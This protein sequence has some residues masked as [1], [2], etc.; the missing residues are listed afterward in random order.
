MTPLW[1]QGCVHSVLPAFAYIQSTVVAC[2]TKWPGICIVVH[3]CCPSPD[4]CHLSHTFQPLSTWITWSRIHN[5]NWF[6]ICHW[7]GVGTWCPFC[8]DKWRNEEASSSVRLMLCINLNSATAWSCPLLIPK[9]FV[10]LIKNQKST[11]LWMLKRNV[12]TWWQTVLPA[13]QWGNRVYRALQHTPGSLNLL[14]TAPTYSLSYYL[15]SLW[16]VPYIHAPLS[17]KAHHKMLSICCC[18]H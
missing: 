17:C 1:Q 14:I 10:F 3:C 7:C 12:L 6:H 5:L 18:N 2:Q 8:T 4:L 16:S 11:Q 15:P 13:R 9:V